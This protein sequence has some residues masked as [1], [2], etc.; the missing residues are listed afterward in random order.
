MPLFTYNLLKKAL[1]TKGRPVSMR[2]IFDQVSGKYT[3]HMENIIHGLEV[4]Q[5]KGLIDSEVKGSVRLFLIRKPLESLDIL[6]DH[7]DVFEN[8]L[9]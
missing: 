1:E 6:S 5:N 8:S 3:V 7:T 9:E 2:E 4:L